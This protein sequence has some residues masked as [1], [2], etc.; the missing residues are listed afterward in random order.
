MPSG[1]LMTTTGS[2]TRKDDRTG[3][4]VMIVDTS[5][6]GQ[7]KVDDR[8]A[9]K[10]PKGILGFPKLT[11]YVLIQPSKDSYFYWL[12]ATEDPSLAFI[13]TDPGHFVPTYRVSLGIEQMQGLALA[14]LEKAQVLVIVNKRD[15]VL[16]GN[17]QGPLVINVATGSGTQLVLSD[18]R[19]TTRVPLIELR[20]P[21]EALTA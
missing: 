1:P 4:F 5:R 21:V 18:R 20:R 15:H 9:I 6:F 10:F 8:M 11:Q 19:Y 7:I 12:H 17:L 13:V 3:A 16:T 2:L 14:S